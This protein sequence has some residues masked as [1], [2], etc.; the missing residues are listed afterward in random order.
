MCAQKERIVHGRFLSFQSQKVVDLG[1]IAVEEQSD[2]N[3][4]S[5]YGYLD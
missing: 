3:R 5:L 1:K 2:C 4:L